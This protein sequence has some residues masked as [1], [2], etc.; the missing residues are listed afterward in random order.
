MLDRAL[1]R[2]SRCCSRALQSDRKVDARPIPAWACTS[3][4]TE[5]PAY[6]SPSTA[7]TEVPGCPCHPNIVKPG[8]R[9]RHAFSG[10]ALL[11]GFSGHLVPPRANP[12]SAASHH[13]FLSVPRVT[14][15]DCQLPL[16]PCSLPSQ[17]AAQATG[18]PSPDSC[19]VG[20]VPYSPPL[21]TSQKQHHPVSP[22]QGLC[23]SPGSW[24]GEDS[25]RIS[26]T[27]TFLW[28]RT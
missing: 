9:G 1:S 18:S 8:E 17:P 6:T 28:P 10:S 5:S 2:T 12:L 14:S 11:P 22:S 3:V 16:E 7:V 4:K 27:L 20:Q 24:E 19:Q 26:F 23:P 21:V 25:S 15:S 13:T